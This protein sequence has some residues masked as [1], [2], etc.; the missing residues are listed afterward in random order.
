MSCVLYFC[1][2][3]RSRSTL[4]FI[5]ISTV[6]TVP[7]LHGLFVI[8][9]LVGWMLNDPATCWSIS[10]RV[11][12][13]KFRFLLTEKKVSNQTQCEVSVH[14]GIH[15]QQRQRQRQRDRE[16]ER[17]RDRE[18]ERERETACLFKFLNSF[19]PCNTAR[20]NFSKFF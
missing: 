20:T 3:R 5:I 1:M 19:F 13:Q 16:R 2:E 11:R 10:G 14:F 7:H 9:L 6:L 15:E 17:E 18:R 8:C 12:S 4:I